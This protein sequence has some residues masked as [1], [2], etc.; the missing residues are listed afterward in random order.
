MTCIIFVEVTG[1]YDL[2]LILI[3]QIETKSKPGIQTFGIGHR[4]VLLGNIICMPSN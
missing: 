1:I 2:Y 4:I 3:L